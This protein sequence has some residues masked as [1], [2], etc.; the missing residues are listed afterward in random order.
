MS[1]K[2]IDKVVKSLPLD[3][4][5]GCLILSLC[6]QDKDAI[7]AISRLIATAGVLGQNILD[8]HNRRRCA[9]MLR[10]VAVSV[11]SEHRS[12]DTASG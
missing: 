1:V 8:E 4:R 11:E 12:I 2:E 5:I 10:D 9:M 3:Q 6:A 7:A